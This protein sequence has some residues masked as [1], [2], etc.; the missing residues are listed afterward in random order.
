MRR[1]RPT[2]DGLEP[3]P[4]LTTVMSPWLPGPAVPVSSHSGASM[5][6]AGGLATLTGSNNGDTITASPLGAGSVEVTVSNSQGTDAF[7]VPAGDVLEVIAGAGA[8]TLDATADPQ[9]LIFVGGSGG[10]RASGGGG[11]NFF[12]STGSGDNTFNGGSFYN[13]FIGA[14][15]GSTVMNGSGVFSSASLCNGTNTFNAGSPSVVYTYGDSHDTINA[16]A[17]DPL[18]V[19]IVGVFDPTVNDGGNPNVTVHHSFF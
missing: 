5:L 1:F 13:V 3:R 10:N 2:V 14:S 7:V 19:Y 12:A 8:N 6:V 18:D 4:L 17:S 15:S 16:D 11:F 9:T